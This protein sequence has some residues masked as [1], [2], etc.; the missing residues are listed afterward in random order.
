MTS[1]FK[2]PDPSIPRKKSA[3]EIANRREETYELHFVRGL[4]VSAISGIQGVS[5]ATVYSDVRAIKE[6]LADT[7]RVADVVEEVALQKSYYGQIRRDAMVEFSRCEESKDKVG[8]LL[9]AL[10]ATNQEANFLINIGFFPSKKQQI[11]LEIRQDIEAKDVG[12]EQLA[13][14]INDPV[15]RTQVLS[16][17]EKL[18]IGAGS[19]TIDAESRVVE[20]PSPDSG[21]QE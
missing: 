20:S 17:L 21:P 6:N 1:P 7:L 16:F 18:K 10:K 4:S 3:S 12:D 19:L 13:E 5:D 9:M 15:Q 2:T 11:D 14:V 8:F